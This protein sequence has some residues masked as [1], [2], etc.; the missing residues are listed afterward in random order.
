MVLMCFFVLYKSKFLSIS[1][2]FSFFILSIIAWLLG[3]VVTW[4]SQNHDLISFVWAPLDYINI[5]A[6]IL[7]AYFFLLLARG[8]DLTPTYKLCLF[9]LS[10]PAWF[11][12]VTN[13]SITAFDVANCE[14]LN[15]GLL[16]NYKLFIEAIMILFII[17]ITLYEVFYKK[18]NRKILLTVSS[19]L[20]AFLVVFS[21][22]EYIASKTGYYEINLYSLFI[23]PIFLLAIIYTITD[24]NIFKIK[25]AGTQ[26]LIYV[27]MV[28]VG[29][30]F[31]FLQ[32]TTD[33][34]LTAVTFILALSFGVLLARDGKK[35]ILQRERIESLANDLSAANARLLELDKQKSEFVSLA[36]HQLRAPLTAM[37]GYSSL[38]LEGD[39]GDINPDAK[40][41]VS[42]IF[43]SANTLANIVN[44]YL[45][46]SRI[47]LGTMKYSF[48][49]HDFKK[50]VED[51]IAELKPNIEKKGLN[52][53][54]NCDANYKY[55][56]HADL[57]K[58]KQVIGNLIDNS[59]KYTPSGSIEVSLVRKSVEGKIVFSIKDTG[60][61]ISSEVMPKLFEKFVRSD[62]AN[63]QNIY[64]TGLGLYIAKQIV[65]AHK[66]R[67]W[68]ESLGDGKGSTFIVELDIEA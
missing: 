54:F 27:M 68:A 4:T 8:K 57:D 36:T 19:S 31:F 55:T 13:Q 60:V 35:E 28:L 45:N 23:L 7:A 65:L 34:I 20:I 44:D 2:V 33:K 50:I 41:A 61:G 53:T 63:K 3:D 42:R 16:T 40:Q 9:S 6:Y 48:D 62:T 51:V 22:T 17:L 43:D 66:G 24:M 67:I 5:I 59:L 18:N 21:I 32:E 58:I 37:K 52:F 46:I 10:I 56:V 64:G 47:E 38:I 25:L 15:N 11:I 14:A 12:T 1:L 39:M 49:K 29:S 30:Q 26:L